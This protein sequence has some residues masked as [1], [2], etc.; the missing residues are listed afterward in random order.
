MMALAAVVVGA[1]GA[2]SYVWLVSGDVWLPDLFWPREHVL[3]EAAVEGRRFALVQTLGMDFYRTE[4]RVRSSTG[5]SAFIVDPDDGK[6]WSARL[7]LR[8]GD[9]TLALH[10]GDEPCG[11]YT[12][13]TGTFRNAGGDAVEPWRSSTNGNP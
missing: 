12:C 3:A 11:T 5:S 9:R 13:E 7:E 2:G 8:P 4:L 6:L 1:T 10:C